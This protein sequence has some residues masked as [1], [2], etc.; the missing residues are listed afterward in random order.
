MGNT[1]VSIVGQQFLIN[2]QPT[3]SGQAYEDKSIEGLLFNSRMVQAI[4]DDENS[5]TQSRWA[6][7]D[8]GKWDADR[9]TTEFVALLPTWRSFGLLGFTLNLQCGNP[10]R[11]RGPG[12]PV[13][14]QQPWE[15]SAY[16]ANGSLKEAWLNRLKRV[17]DEADRLGMV[18][19]L[20]LFYF[21]QDHRLEDE[22]AVIRAAENVIRWLDDN[23]VTNVV[24]EV[25]NECNVP[26]Y[27]HELLKPERIPE[28][29]QHVRGLTNRP[30]SA[31][32]ASLPED[33][34]PPAEL[35]G[36]VDFVLLHANGI[37]DPDVIAQMVADSRAKAYQT[38]GAK[39]IV[40]N[41][42][43]HFDFYKPRNNFLAAVENYASWG[44]FDPGENNDY[45]DGFQCPPVQWGLST[46]LKRSFSHEL[47][48]MT[49]AVW[50]GRA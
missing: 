22:A 12:G 49:G 24:I 14:M 10:V 34:L 6:Y 28:L 35:V 45:H 21:G 9:N 36:A 18:V 19:I 32:Y 25:A 3:Y 26:R 16:L 8:T 42:D 47:G 2:G 27:S 38:G 17:I 46:P 20:G 31:S 43:N 37:N 11:G 15:V 39:P 48:R 7:P 40:F 33:Y 29:M 5:E 13:P 1:H 4:F 41:E 30:I 50:S 23:D 44:F